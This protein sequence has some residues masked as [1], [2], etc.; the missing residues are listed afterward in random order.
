MFQT[1]IKKMN[2]L[3]A[4]PETA[5]IWIY[6]ASRELTERE[7]E[8]AAGILAAF[9]DFWESHGEALKAGFMVEDRR[10]V[11]LGIDEMVNKPGGCAL[12]A[13]VAVIKKLEADFN[14]SLLDRNTICF[15]SQDGTIFSKNISELKSAVEKGEIS[16]QTLVYDNTV[17]DLQSFYVRRKTEAGNTWLKR[18][19]FKN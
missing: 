19:F 17:G 13:S 4:L 11:I 8:K 15:L 10:F 7:A 1:K 12:D 18:Y 14:I 16:P 5:K 2:T 9:T 3:T 6:Q